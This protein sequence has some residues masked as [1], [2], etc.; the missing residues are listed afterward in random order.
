MFMCLNCSLCGL[1]LAFGLH[2]RLL[3]CSTSLSHS[4]RHS[5]DRRPGR[6][7]SLIAYSL[8]LFSVF[9][10]VFL[11]S[12]HGSHLC[13]IHLPSPKG[14][15][16][17]GVQP[18]CCSNG[19]WLCCTELTVLDLGKLPSTRTTPGPEPSPPSPRC[20]EPKPEPTVDGEHMPAAAD[21]PSPAG[22]TE[23][24]ITPEPESHYVWP[25]TRAGNWA[26]ADGLCKGTW[27]LGEKPTH[28]TT[29]EGEHPLDSED[30]MDPFHK[31]MMM[32]LKVISIVNP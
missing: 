8:H 24:R 14:P 6:Q 5:A 12:P 31:T 30:Q 7:R 22:A 28:C 25:G 17:L 21:E 10:S 16:P 4:L 11:F 27:G 19:V 2:K 20:A 18:A 9:C 1:P 15:A 32:R 3:V 13:K 23:L 26:C 29:A